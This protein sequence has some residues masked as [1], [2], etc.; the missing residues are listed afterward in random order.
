MSAPAATQFSATSLI[1]MWLTKS[2][3]SECCTM[4]GTEV[5]AD[6]QITKDLNVYGLGEARSLTAYQK[7]CG[8][9]F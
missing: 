8:R 5:S 4:L 1:G 9:E 3:K 7:I 2:P 6:P